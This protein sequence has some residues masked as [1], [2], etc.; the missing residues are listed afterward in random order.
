M[1]VYAKKHVQ[2]VVVY[3]AIR[4]VRECVEWGVLGVFT[5]RD[6]NMKS[7]LLFIVS[8]IPVILWGQEKY[9]LET[10]Y[11]NPVDTVKF[12]EDPTMLLF[13]HSKCQSR[14]CAT[15]RM[16]I[17][18]ERDSLGFRA[19]FGIKLYV[20]YP[21]YSQSDI[22]AFDTFS[23]TENAVVAFYTSLNHKN[24]FYEGN[25]TPHVVFYDGKGHVYSKTGGTIEELNDSV[26]NKWRYSYEK[27]PVCKGTGKVKLKRQSNDPDLAVGICRRCSGGI[28]GKEEVY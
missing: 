24:T 25:T 15:T 3:N 6:N 1:Q 12:H 18:L 21:K 22:D 2:T 19:R 11:R 9:V 26:Y 27:C 17:A 5:L 8:C 16:Q 20:I 23:P 10:R 14:S 28:I 4:L 7:L 13:V